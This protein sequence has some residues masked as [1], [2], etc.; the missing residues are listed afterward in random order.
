VF[1][2]VEARDTQVSEGMQEG[3]VD[4]YERLDEQLARGVPVA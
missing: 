2:T 4:S 3:I 1:Q